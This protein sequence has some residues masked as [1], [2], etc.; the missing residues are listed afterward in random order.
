MKKL[1]KKKS[2]KKASS[3]KASAKKKVT[4]KITNQK[5]SKKNPSLRKKS[6]SGRDWIRYTDLIPKGGD[7][8]ESTKY[9]PLKM[10]DYYERL[11]DLADKIQKKKEKDYP[12]NGYPRWRAIEDAGYQ[13]EKKQLDK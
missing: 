4:K 12:I 6:E 7:F 13:L 10:K 8:R 9:E 5:T 1:A 11:N 2:S 3:K